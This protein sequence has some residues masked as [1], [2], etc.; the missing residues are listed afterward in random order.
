MAIPTPWPRHEIQIRWDDPNDSPDGGRKIYP[1]MYPIV[2]AAYHARGGNDPDLPGRATVSGSGRA[3]VHVA[4]DADG[5]LYVFS[6]NDGIIRAVS[7]AR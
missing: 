6:K 1:T 4:V 5:E 3:D 7:H 2:E